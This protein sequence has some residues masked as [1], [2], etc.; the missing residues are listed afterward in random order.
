MTRRVTF[1]EPLDRALMPFGV[2]V[3]GESVSWPMV[4]CR[5]AVL[6]A[7]SFPVMPIGI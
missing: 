1:L 4:L 2:C 6:S 3:G 7:V 5:A